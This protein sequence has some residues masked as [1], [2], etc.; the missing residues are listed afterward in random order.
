MEIDNQKGKLEV[1]EQIKANPDYYRQIVEMAEEGIWVINAENKTTF[2]NHRMAE[3]LGCTLAELMGKS[4]FDFID[5]EWTPVAQVNVIRRRQSIR[6]Q[7]EFKF[8]R[9]DGGILWT[10]VN[11]TPIFENEQYVGALGM[12]TDITAR[13]EAE[14]A[15]QQAKAELEFRVQLRTA[16]LIE[17]NQRLENEIAERVLAEEVL[18]LER[19]KLKGILATLPGGVYILSQDC[20]L[21]YINPY[22]ER[23]FGP[24]NGLKCYQYFHDRSERCPWCVNQRVFSGETV[25]WEWHFEK[26]NRTFELFDTPLCNADGSISKLEI[27]YDIT[28]RKEA[29]NEILQRNRELTAINEIGR[30]ITSSLDL[31]HILAELLVRLQQVTGAQLCTVGLID[32]ATDEVTFYQPNQ[33]HGVV[34]LILEQKFKKGEGISGWVIEHKQPVVLSDLTQDARPRVD[35]YKQFN[36]YPRSMGSVPLIVQDKVIGTIGMFHEEIGMFDTADLR[37]VGA[38]A[39][40][41]AVAIQNAALYE[42]EQKAR[43]RAETL[44]R[45]GLALSSSLNL[46]TVLE[47][48]LD[49]L[50]AVVPYESAHV[51]L[52][53]NQDNASMRVTRAAAGRASHDQQVERRI[54]V[55]RAPLLAPIFEGSTLSLEQPF[56]EPDFALIANRPHLQSWLGIPLVAEGQ[57]IGFC[58]LEHSRPAFFSRDLIHWAEALISQAAIA[59]QNAWLFEQVRQGRQ[60]LQALSRRL[61]E[62]QESERHYIARE[63]HDEAG[64]TLASLMIGLHLIEREAGDQPMI[65]ER[66]QQLKA[67]ANN[68]I[69]EIHRLAID[70]RPA[71]LDHLGLVPALQQHVEKVSDLHRLTIEFHSNEQVARLPGEVETAIYR[72]VQEALTNIVRHAQATRADVLLDWRADKLIVIVEDNGTGFDPQKRPTDRL[73]M[74]GMRER[75]DMLGGSLIIESTPGKGSTIYLEVPYAYSNIDRR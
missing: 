30:A 50:S 58:A 22:M 71:S 52:L 51:Y 16:E 54:E 4:L 33:Q 40:Q 48:L 74:L 69:E 23:T 10:I 9:A 39:S 70:L 27:F 45:A 59:I 20:N 37:L 57:V 21:E 67:I 49:H 36:F 75:A 63:L 66:C 61:V 72:I 35:L 68:V 18:H 44:R 15:L 13:K 34:E 53:D 32:P 3:M 31:H 62:V 7:H 56:L 8:K 6:E 14:D 60:R 55:A 29:E 65:V 25:Q 38:I 28:I 47:T 11:A 2:A 41:A 42:A 46:H 5:E 64:Q 43:H 73:G 1:E 17:I 19:S 26:V 24:V 12:I